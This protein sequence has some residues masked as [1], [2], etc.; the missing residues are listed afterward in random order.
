MLE[1]CPGMFVLLGG[2]KG[3]RNGHQYT[4]QNGGTILSYGDLP[5]CPSLQHP[6]WPQNAHGG[7][8]SALGV[9][10]GGWERSERFSRGNWVKTGGAVPTKKLHT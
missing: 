6:F 1:A 5:A 9:H 3:S 7:P 2:R 4:Q 10:T 8:T